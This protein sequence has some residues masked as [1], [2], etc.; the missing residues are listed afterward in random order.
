MMR[1]FLAA[2]EH[3]VDLAT[4]VHYLY[5]TGFLTLQFRQAVRGNDGAML[6]LLYREFYQLAYTGTANK[7]M[8]GQ[9]AIARVF[10]AD[11]LEPE[12]AAI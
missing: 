5:D 6:D 3:N 11:A 10:W 9:V 1:Q 8:Y 12:L 4:V 2:C 7:V